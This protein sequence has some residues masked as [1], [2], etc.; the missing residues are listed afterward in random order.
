MVR[1]RSKRDRGRDGTNGAIAEQHVC[2]PEEDRPELRTA[3]GARR[4][5]LAQEPSAR[6]SGEDE[7]L[8]LV[9]AKPSEFLIHVRGGRI[10]ERTTGPGVTCFKWPWDSV[11]IVPTT[12]NRLQFVADQVTR[13]KVG[14]EVCGLAVYRIVDP[15]VAYRMLN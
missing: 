7:A 12:I 15:L 5:R 3:E 14:V 9:T 13:E 2:S 4:L 11:A 1:A 6:R 8:G 10:V